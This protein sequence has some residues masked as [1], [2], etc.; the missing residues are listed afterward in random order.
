MRAA[1]CR[2]GRG[3]ALAGLL[4]G[5]AL[6][7]A[8]AAK[9]SLPLPETRGEYGWAQRQRI[10]YRNVPL[11]RKAVDALAKGDYAAAERGLREV[12]QHD[13]LNNHARIYLVEALDHLG[14]WAEGMAVCDELTA[15]YPD[16]LD[17][18]LNKGYMGIKAGRHAEAVAALEQFLARAP[19]D[20]PARVAVEKNLSE[21]CLRT[22]DMAGAE[23][24]GGLWLQHE[25]GVPARLFM[26]ECGIRQK[27]WDMA[28]EHLDRALAFVGAPARRGEL[29]LKRAYVLGN[30]ERFDEAEA[31]FLQV[32]NVLPGKERRLEIEAQLGYNAVRSRQPAKAAD[33]FKTYLLESFSEPI[34]TAYLDALTAADQWE[35]AL[36]EGRNILKH[37]PLTDAF[38]EATLNRMLDAARHQDDHLSCYLVAQQLHTRFPK[39]RYLLEMARAAERMGQIDE[40][41]RVYKR[42]L[43]EEFNPDVALGYHYLLKPKGLLE[44]SAGVLERVR[45]APGAT[46]AQRQAATYEL[47]QV[48]RVQ[49]RQDRYFELMK[50]LVKDRPQSRFFHE[51]AVQ[52]YGIGRYEMAAEMFIRSLEGEPDAARKRETCLTIADIYLALRRPDDAEKWLRAGR[53]FGPTDAAWEFAMARADYQR[54]RYRD[55]VD[56]LLPLAQKQDVYH[57]YLGFSFYQMGMPGLAVFHLNQVAAS[58]KLTTDEQFTLFANRAYLQYDQDQ[59]EAALADLER[60]LAYRKSD[61]LDLVRLRTLG[62]LG[63]DEEVIEAGQALLSEEPESE[64][65]QDIQEALKDHPD[66]QFRRDMLAL[67]G[68]P[69]DEFRARVALTI[70][71]AHFRLGRVG[72]ALRYYGMA[73]EFD[74]ELI[75]AYYDRGLAHYRNGDYEKA[76]DDFLTYYDK[77]GKGAG[78]TPI[79]W[80]D[81]GLI[82]GKLKDYDLGTAALTQSLDAYPHDVDTLEER[83]YQYMKWSKNKEATADF[84]RAIDVY[85]AVEPYLD[86]EEAQEY[87]DARRAMKQ[88][89]AKL[90]KRFGFQAYIHKTDLDAETQEELPSFQTIEGALPSQA[91]ISIAYR[92]PKI[93]FRNERQLD[94]FLRVLANFKPN[95]WEL[96]PDSYQGGV[97]VLYKP[98]VRFNYTVGFERLFKIGENSENN[99]LWRNLASW[100]WGEKPRRDARLWLFSKVY[101]EL[102]FFLEEPKRWVFYGNVRAGPNIFLPKHL[103]I[104]LPEGLFIVRKESSDDTHVKSYTM[105]GAGTNVRWLEDRERAYTRDIWYIDLFVHYVVGWFDETPHGYE[106]R[107]FDGFMFGFNVYK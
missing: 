5:A 94:V 46:P 89:T 42:Y 21:I 90:Q 57:L 82:E 86:G 39:P 100:E 22:D 55:C 102:S 32:K 19:S 107:Q 101:A 11:L 18:Y 105:I 104:T 69:R 103:L 74:P 98:L 25:D 40:A 12:L 2:V 99:W 29:Q 65:R 97:G 91:G 88:E 15:A 66:A 95:S 47:A 76:E 54:E 27:K 41:L 33:H 61:E 38:R 43:A 6:A 56:R 60:A 1:A 84:K 93:G 17:G 9:P 77:S 24:Y 10:R 7:S 83:G 4:A 31:A 106:E 62:R 75:E 73:L 44:E 85:H 79:L 48:F 72:D 52:L 13:P 87:V 67:A 78:L 51:Y 3:L 36:V 35:L 68:T 64:L 59:D 49:G 96:D 70:A 81:L 92:P 45:A 28:L 50:E 71:R 34:A 37:S 16:Y 26:A 30:L 8:Q 63:R 53:E 20:Y 80:G 14:R 23:R 58:E